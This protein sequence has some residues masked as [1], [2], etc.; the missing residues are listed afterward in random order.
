MLGPL[1]LSESPRRSMFLGP[2]T[3]I[4]QLPGPVRSPASLSNYFTNT[5][6]SAINILVYA[7][8]KE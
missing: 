5:L 6:D 8:Y 4:T 1:G 3:N 7:D 2:F